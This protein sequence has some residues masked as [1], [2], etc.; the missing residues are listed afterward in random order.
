MPLVTAASAPGPA[1]RLRRVLAYRI[2]VKYLVLKDIKVKSRGTY[3]GVLWTLMN[4]L[5]T[6]A[7]Y[8]VVFRHVFR[9][10]IPNFLTFFLV[11]FLP[12]VFFSR[13]ATAAAG[14]IVDS[15]AL[16]KRAVFPLE[17]L[18]IAS[19]LYHLF[20][21]AVALA[22][23]LPVMIG[24]GGARVSGHLVWLL[25]IVAAFALFTLGVALAVATMGVF[26]RDTR[27][28]LDVLLPVLF[29]ATPIFYAA[30]MAPPFLQPVLQLNP[31]VPFIE[32]ART[33]L[34][35]GQ[36]PGGAAVARMAGWLAAAVAGG[37]L[38]F[39]RHDRAVA[40]EL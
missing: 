13:A 26:F 6:I 19:V 18:P 7:V 33:V 34:L 12:W 29:W 40:E 3:L 36:A 8:Y 25:P 14:C 11:G 9:V 30:S 4:P 5:L 23:V 27:D 24:L 31:I 10:D 22:L 35:D 20:H 2:L 32:A 21:H 37:A 1:A 28:I 15:E 39:A 16:V 38:L 17:A